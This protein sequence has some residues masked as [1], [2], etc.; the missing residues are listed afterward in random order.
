MAHPKFKARIGRP[1][2]PE[3]KQLIYTAVCRL[4]EKDWDMLRIRASG[5]GIRTSEFMRR[6]IKR[7][8]R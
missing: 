1:P 4:D 7:A 5:E 8:L 3:N 2:I 6:A